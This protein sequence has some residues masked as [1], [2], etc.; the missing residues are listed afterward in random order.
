MTNL[1]TSHLKLYS[2]LLVMASTY[3]CKFRN[4]QASDLLGEADSP[5]IQK[6]KQL[7]P[8]SCES[9][10]A[11]LFK[12]KKAEIPKKI[13]IKT[14]IDNVFKIQGAASTFGVIYDPSAALEINKFIPVAFEGR[15]NSRASLCEMK[16]S[17]IYFML[18]PSSPEDIQ[19][20]ALRPQGRMG[21]DNWK[22]IGIAPETH[23]KI[24]DDM[25]ASGIQGDQKRRQFYYDAFV[26][27]QVNQTV[28]KDGFPQDKS[29]FFGQVGDDLKLVTH[30]GKTTQA[31]WGGKDYPEQQAHLLNEFYIYRLLNEWK[32]TIIKT[33]LL[34][35]TYVRAASQEAMDFEGH[36]SALGFL[37]ESRTKLANRCGLLSELPANTGNAGRDEVS[38]TQAN[39]LNH[40]FV[41]LD[42]SADFAHNSENIYDSSGKE[43][44]TTYDFD[45]S[46][47]WSETY[48]KNPG[49]IEQNAENFKDFLSEKIGDEKYLTQVLFVL[50]KMKK[51]ND[52]IDKIEAVINPNAAPEQKK[53]VRWIKAFEPVLRG[54]VESHRATHGPYIEAV[55]KFQA[56]SQNEQPDPEG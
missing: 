32:S 38:F 4:D 27:S 15:G 37:R 44:V 28:P 33:S 13:M 7:K 53:F 18:Q 52:K 21:A 49:T 36:S 41:S 6:Y 42:Y 3:A 34:D 17:R 43:F 22:T 5:E 19:K 8:R 10:K 1:K 35:I 48:F 30:C 25:N 14:D 24:I 45:L 2:L 9:S 50:G 31:E 20:L 46:G 39:F 40:L 54:F 12:N 47:I 16:P 23:K 51:I 29:S 26:A 11:E 56:K 55:E